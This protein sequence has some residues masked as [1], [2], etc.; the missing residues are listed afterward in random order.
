MYLAISRIGNV[1]AVKLSLLRDKN[2]PEDIIVTRAQAKKQPTPIHVNRIE[3]NGKSILN[4]DFENFGNNYATIIKSK[5]EAELSKGPIDGVLIDLRSNGGGDVNTVTQ[6]AMLF[7]NPDQNAVWFMKNPKYE[8]ASTNL[9]DDRVIS[10][11][12]QLVDGP[13]VVLVNSGSASASEILAGTLKIHGRAIVVGSPQTYGKGSVQNITQRVTNSS[14]IQVPL[15]G[16]IKSTVALY[17][18]ADGSTPQY[19]GVKSDIKIK[20]SV[21][22]ESYMEKNQKAAIKPIPVENPLASQFNP[23]T[24]ESKPELLARSEK[25]Q[26]SWTDESKITQEMVLTEAQQILSDWIDMKGK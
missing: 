1:P 4:I 24:I 16:G 5:I 7:Q 3:V 23:V 2:A 14:G 15:D 10:N 8:D 17:Y 18:L 22:D 9:D 21:Y 13:I 20:G 6:L 26:E 11:F 12:T 19:E 25:R